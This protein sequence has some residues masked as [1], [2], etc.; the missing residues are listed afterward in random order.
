ML[1]LFTMVF[2]GLMW[3]SRVMRKQA[4]TR[5][6]MVTSDEGPV[7]GLTGLLYWTVND[8]WAEA[9]RSNSKQT[10]VAFSRCAIGNIRGLLFDSLP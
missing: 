4:T 6:F 2:S 5:A 7:V 8:W 10:H 1:R 3:L 9:F